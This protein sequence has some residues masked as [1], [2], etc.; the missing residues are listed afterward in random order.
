MCNK[1]I[2]AFFIVGALL[3]GHVVNAQN[4]SLELKRPTT[5]VNNTLESVEVFPLPKVP[6]ELKTP[7]E[8][9]EYILYHYWDE[10]DMSQKF[11]QSKRTFLEHGFV[12][13]IQL[14]P[15]ADSDVIARSVDIMFDKFETNRPALDMLMDVAFKY[16][17]EP[18]SPYYDERYFVFILKRELASD[19]LSDMDKVRPDYL[20]ESAMKN[21]PGSF[22]TDFEFITS[23]GRK[24]SLY[25]IDALKTILIFYDPDCHHCKEVISLLA[26]SKGLNSLIE[27]GEVKV[28]AIYPFDD[29]EAWSEFNSL[30]PS[31]WTVGINSDTI[32][33]DQ[34]YVFPVLPTLYLLDKDK[35]VILKDTT[36]QVL[37]KNL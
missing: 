23:K 15:L 3:L 2:R 11:N 5:T 9:A 25:D 4:M 6:T 32:D 24:M 14:F 35:K 20:L 34:L 33:N 22:A 12:D 17:Y 18:E 28:L 37:F 26:K 16:L 27:S 31:L 30:M 36:T 13:Y 8:R 19:V 10:L 7:S 1:V 29:H 21:T